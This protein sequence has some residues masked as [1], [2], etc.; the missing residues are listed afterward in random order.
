MLDA[1]LIN[2]CL[3]KQDKNI[4]KEI[5]SCFPAVG[6]STIAAYIRQQGF[7]VK[8]IDAPALRLAVESFKNYLKDKFE[9]RI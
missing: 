6:L 7:K 4:W 1:L 8:I 9:S 3:F 5:D 2:P